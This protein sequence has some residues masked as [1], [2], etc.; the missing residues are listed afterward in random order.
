VVANASINL[1]AIQDSTGGN[2]IT[3]AGCPA[4]GFYVSTGAG[5]I[6]TTTPALTAAASGRNLL[7]ITYDGSNCYVAVN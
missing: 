5:L 3:L 6:S 4:G 2:T 1:I 7:S